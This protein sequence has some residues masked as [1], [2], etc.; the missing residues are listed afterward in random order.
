[1]AVLAFGAAHAAELG[2]K[3]IIQAENELGRT[4]ASNVRELRSSENYCCSAGRSLCLWISLGLRNRCQGE[5]GIPAPLVGRTAL[6]HP[7][8]IA[9]QQRRSSELLSSSSKFPCA[10]SLGGEISSAHGEI[11]EQKHR[12]VIKIKPQPCRQRAAIPGATPGSGADGAGAVRTPVGQSTLTL[13]SSPRNKAAR[14][15]KGPTVEAA[16]ARNC[17]SLDVGTLESAGSSG[18]SGITAGN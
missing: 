13:Q 10:A 11:R 14:T 3:D 5:R 12:L 7:K 2:I 6:P 16:G 17:D 8:V 9:T 4:S 1:M 15:H 18:K